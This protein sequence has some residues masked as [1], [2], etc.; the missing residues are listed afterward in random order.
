MKHRISENL[1]FFKAGSGLY[2]ESYLAKE[3]A[4]SLQADFV[5]ID[6]NLQNTTLI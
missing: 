3:S 6:R 5:A 1:A 4:A 2:D